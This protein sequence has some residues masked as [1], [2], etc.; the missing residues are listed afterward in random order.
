MN[1][2]RLSA[3]ILCAALPLAVQAQWRWTDKDG[4]QVFSDTPPPA[5]IPEQNVIQRGNLPAPRPAQAV[6]PAAPAANGNAA[7]M[8]QAQAPV[9]KELDEKVRK[10][11]EA[12]KAQKEAEERKVAEAK[13]DNC[14]RA[15]ESKATYDSGIRVARV[16]AQG[17][18]EI[19]DDAARASETRRLQSIIDSDCKR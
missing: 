15:R 18:R 4:R 14:N 13:A 1:V 12:E 17:E 2:R 5:S 10:A 9:D 8:P 11:A 3:L 19:I 6:A 7:P 16:N